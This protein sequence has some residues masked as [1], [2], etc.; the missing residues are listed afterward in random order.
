V[1]VL[2]SDF[3]NDSSYATMDGVLRNRITNIRRPSVR[4]AFETRF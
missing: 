4:A 3:V 1:N 2:G